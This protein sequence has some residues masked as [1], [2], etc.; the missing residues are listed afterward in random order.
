MTTIAVHLLD[1][2]AKEL[3]EGQEAIKVFHSVLGIT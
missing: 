3:R 1:M 2:R